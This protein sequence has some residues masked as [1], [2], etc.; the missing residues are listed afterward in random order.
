MPD[1]DLRAR[2][3]AVLESIARD[4]TNRPEVRLEAARELIY[5]TVVDAP[6]E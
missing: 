4:L 6:D 1:A 3:L 5:A 2:A